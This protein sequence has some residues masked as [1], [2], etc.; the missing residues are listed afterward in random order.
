[1]IW[2]RIHKSVVK[3]DK[4]AKVLYSIQNKHK[5]NFNTHTN[6]SMWFDFKSLENAKGFIQ[7]LEEKLPYLKWTLGN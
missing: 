2:V 3:C 7:A 1:M 6:R 5:A 4:D